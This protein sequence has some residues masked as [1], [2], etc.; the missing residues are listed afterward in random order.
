MA[1][2]YVTLARLRSMSEVLV[3]EATAMAAETWGARSRIMVG[4]V[5]VV[6]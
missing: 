4:G 2:R 3:A 1:L 5:T 6:L